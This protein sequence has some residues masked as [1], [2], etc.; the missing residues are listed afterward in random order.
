MEKI[1]IAFYFMLL[2]IASM[3][4]PET[5]KTTD[6]DSNRIS[7]EISDYGLIFTTIQ[8][9]G[10]E[11]K[12]MI[13]L[14][15]Q[16]ELQLSSGL[17][18][19]L[20]IESEKTNYKVS[21]I[22]GNLWD[23]YKGEIEEFAVGNWKEQKMEF[24]FQVGEMEAVSQQIGTDF[25]A[26]LGWGF[27]KNFITEID[28]I[29]GHMTLHKDPPSR[30]SDSF[31]GPFRRDAD[32]LIISVQID[33]SNHNVMIDTGSPVTVVDSDLAQSISGDIFRFK[34]HGQPVEL[35]AYS[36]DLSVLADLGVVA[37]LGGD[38]LQQWTV[39]LNPLDSVI[40]FSRVNVTES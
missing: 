30:G 12:A 21:D 20:G 1:C 16:H 14:G 7:F 2:G 17:V 39:I 33:G 6:P 11:V 29:N 4:S 37:I 23:V 8:V 10:S 38:F 9:N 32:Q 36:Q 26:V 24:T 19:K 3:T 18:E 13:D 22:H 15:D 5:V 34:L 40:H 31:Q 35:K 25:D 27:F 28:Y